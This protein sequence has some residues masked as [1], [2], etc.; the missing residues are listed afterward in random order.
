[1]A[2]WRGPGRM[3]IRPGRDRR[4]SMNWKASAGVD[5]GSKILGLVATRTKPCST[6]SE[7]AKGSELVQSAGPMG[8]DQ[9]ID[10][11]H[12]HGCYRVA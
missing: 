2:Q 3:E 9:N 11:G 4:A 12:L 7:R 5:G 1:M 8:V 6:S 10:I